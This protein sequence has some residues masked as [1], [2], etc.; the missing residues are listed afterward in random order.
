MFALGQRVNHSVIQ[1]W[2]SNPLVVGREFIRM[3]RSLW[4]ALG[5]GKG[6]R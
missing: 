2:L 4:L 6:L 5:E 1:R 3:N